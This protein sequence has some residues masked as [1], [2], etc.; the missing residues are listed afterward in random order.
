MSDQQ[1]LV[2][3]HQQQLLVPANLKHQLMQFGSLLHHEGCPSF[4]FA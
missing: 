4:D 1:F 2:T 3:K